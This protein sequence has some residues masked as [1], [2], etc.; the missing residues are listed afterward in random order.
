MATT[1]LL[2]PD[3][4]DELEDSASN[5]GVTEHYAR[6]VTLKAAQPVQKSLLWPSTLIGSAKR[7]NIRLFSPEVSHLHCSISYDSGRL[8]LVDLH[9]AK[10][11][12]N[13]DFGFRFAI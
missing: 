4:P 8:S 6:L 7:S 9:A 11:P 10:I 13:T 1:E 2:G 3:S 12:I 5:P